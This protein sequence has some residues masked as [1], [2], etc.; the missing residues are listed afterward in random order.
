MK[1]SEINQLIYEAK[2]FFE[3]M[4][5]KLPPWG[6]WSPEKWKGNAETCAEV[7]ENMLGWDL[8][9]SAAELARRLEA[10]AEDGHARSC[11]VLADHLARGIQ[12][13]RD[14]ERART[15]W[16]VAARSSESV[17]LLL[18]IAEVLLRNKAPVLH[19]PDEARRWLEKAQ[20]IQPSL[21]HSDRFRRIE[22]LLPPPTL[23]AMAAR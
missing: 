7:A 3:K 5:F 2:D 11:A 17:D 14:L 20:D 4:N 19:D 18:A 10:Q 1:R 16:R 22:A 6:Y 23:A 8:T 15:L 9:D 21:V 12:W 13:S